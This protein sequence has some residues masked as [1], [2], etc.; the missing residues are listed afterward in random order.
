MRRS[1]YLALAIIATCSQASLAQDD[2]EQRIRKALEGRFVLT[3]MDLP[4][5]ETGVEMIFD[6]A[7]VSYDDAAYKK[8]VKQY[9]VAVKKG[10][11]AKITAV[12]IS[13][14][15]IEIDL[16]GGGSPGREWIVKGMTLT[17]PLPAPKSDRE[18]DLERQLQLEHNAEAASYLR[19]EIEYERQR[20]VTQDERN[21]TTYERMVRLRS[22]YIEENRKSWGSKLIVVVRSRKPSVTMRDMMTSLA[23][24]VEILPREPAGQ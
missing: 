21:R 1:V 17:D 16:D 7:N 19:A 23:R 9:G 24:Y 2:G 13:A 5:I 20:R 22:E 6:D 11:R 12:R 3:K 10:S 14:K 15:G 4:A 18:I 8:L